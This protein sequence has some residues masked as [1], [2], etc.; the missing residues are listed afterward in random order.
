M[1]RSYIEIN[2]TRYD[3]KVETEEVRFSRARLA[4]YSALENF[5]ME[6]EIKG[7]SRYELLEI[8]NLVKPT[9]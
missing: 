3:V 7:L 1:E 2:G 4:V 9:L 5:A 6:H 8:A